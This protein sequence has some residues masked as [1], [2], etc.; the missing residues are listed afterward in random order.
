MGVLMLALALFT[1]AVVPNL[2]AKAVAGR[3]RIG[4]VPPPPHLGQCLLQ[5]PPD[6]TILPSA[7]R[8]YRLGN[9][10]GAHYGE[11]AR[12]IASASARPNSIGGSAAGSTAAGSTTGSAAGDDPCADVSEYLGWKPPIAS[13]TNVSWQPISV[14]VINMVPVALQ[15]AFGQHWVACVITPRVTGASYAGSIRN[16]LS[17]GKLP[18]VFANCHLSPVVGQAG[19]I[20]CRLP[21]RYEIFGYAKLSGGYHDQ[22]ALD[23]ECRKIVTAAI[24]RS[25]PSVGGQLRISSV[26]FHR[27]AAGN[28]QAGYPL[29]AADSDAEGICA[30]GVTGSRFLVGSLFGL[31]EQPLPWS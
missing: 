21:H 4:A 15:T 30:A 29:R 22:N 9:C 27:D 6:P 26:P 7:Q 3:A 1:A 23:L 16:A 2:Q 20:A 10:S 13:T 8:S 24:S 28:P 11:V 25:D 17:S 5:N 14:S 18:T 31:G 19:L 12:I